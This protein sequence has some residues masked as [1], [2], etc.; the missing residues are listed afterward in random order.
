MRGVLEGGP[1]DFCLVRQRL[2]G[3][4]AGR[5]RPLRVP[6]D[7]AEAFQNASPRKRRRSEQAMA[8]ALMSREEVVKMFRDIT[9]RASEYAA[10]QGLTSEKLDELLRKGDGE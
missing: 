2:S 9:E 10:E 3:E 4:K 5:D 1:G 6:K 7:I 8:S